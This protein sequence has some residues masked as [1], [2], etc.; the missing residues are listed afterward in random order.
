LNALLGRLENWISE[1]RV[2]TVLATHDATDAFATG[3]EV[4]LLREGCL[5]AL[6]PAD[7]ALASERARLLGRIG[8][9]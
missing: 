3:A 2:Q 9:P 7:E 8:T 1:H 4:A 6:G 5:A